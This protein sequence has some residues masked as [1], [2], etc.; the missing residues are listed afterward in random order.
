LTEMASV[1]MNPK[2]ELQMHP[3]PS[4]GTLKPTTSDL[5]LYGPGPNVLRKNLVKCTCSSQAG[6]CPVHPTQ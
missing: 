2:F 5:G 4:S 1:N 6:G 3:T